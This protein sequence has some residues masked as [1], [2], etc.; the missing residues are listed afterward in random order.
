MSDTVVDWLRHGEPRGGRR[1]R[2]WID[3]PLSE[4]GWAQMWAAVEVPGPW[5]NIISSPLLRCSAFGRALAERMGLPYA[6]DPRLREVGYG[7]WE[8]KSGIDLKREDPQVLVRFYRDPAGSRPPDAEPL[9]AFQQ[10]VSEAFDE[11][12]QRFQGRHVLVITHAG[13]IRAMI[14][15]V[16]AA[17][18]DSLYRIS[19]PNASLARVRSNVERPPTL[20]FHGRPSL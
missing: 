4:R 8:G 15:H 9:M 10:R 11:I 1:Y 7:A 2:G 13:V 19:V 20:V 6:E 16:V 5:E 3:D 14:A 18:V 17:P 12:Q